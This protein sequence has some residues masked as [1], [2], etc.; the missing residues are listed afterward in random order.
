MIFSDPGGPF[1]RAA[2][3]LLEA[4]RQETGY[5]FVTISSELRLGRPE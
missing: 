4:D 3:L 5:R 1:I 2:G